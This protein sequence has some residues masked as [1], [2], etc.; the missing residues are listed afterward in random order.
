MLAAIALLA[1]CTQQQQDQT[2]RQVQTAVSAIPSPVKQGANDAALTAAVAG[3]IAA[4]TGV[5]VFHVTPRVSDGIVTLKGTAPTAEIKSTI[6]DAVRKVK[7]VRQ[8]VD[9]IAVR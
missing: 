6:I 1:A 2:Q 4:Q 3:A 5:N 9:Q 8:I 7:G